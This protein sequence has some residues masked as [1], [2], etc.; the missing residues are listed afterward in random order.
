LGRLKIDIKFDSP[1]GA[2]PIDDISGLK[3]FWVKTQEDL[4]RV[5]AENIAKAT[6]QYLMKSVNK[7]K[8]W[9]HLAE[10]KNIHKK[11]YFDVWDWAGIYITTQTLP[12]VKSYLINSL[13]VELCSDVLH[14]CCNTCELTFIEQAARIHHRLVFIHPFLNGNGRFARLIADRYL[15]AW[16]CEFPIWPIDIQNNGQLRK[17]YI[18]SLKSADAGDYTELI[19]FMKT[20]GAK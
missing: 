20:C 4:N 14:W 7:P 2:T 1:D 5:E 12:G 18:S 10:L 6:Y 11:M 19:Y 15:K 17:Q 3:I 13:L 16:K 8:L 9:F